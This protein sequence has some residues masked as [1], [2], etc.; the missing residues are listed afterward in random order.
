M[1]ITG[2]F[3]TVNAVSDKYAQLVISK[4]MAGKKRLISV[5]LF[6]WRKDK[7]IK[8]LRPMKGDKVYATVFF[9]TELWKGRYNTKIVLKEIRIES[10]KENVPSTR[11]GEIDYPTYSPPIKNS[12]GD[13]LL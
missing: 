10:K 5:S 8:E 3:V 2:R 6:G 11:H 4:T 12:E 13:I 1:E 7:V 9:E